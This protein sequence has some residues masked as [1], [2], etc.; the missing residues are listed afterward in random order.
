MSGAENNFDSLGSGPGSAHFLSEKSPSLPDDGDFTSKARWCF[1][2]F[3][4]REESSPI[5]QSPTTTI[6]SGLPRRGDAI[7]AANLIKG[8]Q[9]D[10]LFTNGMPAKDW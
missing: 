6:R 8:T 9:H 7:W 1:A 10:E 3:L 5:R 4:H 2:A